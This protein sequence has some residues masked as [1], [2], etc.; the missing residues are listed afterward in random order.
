MKNNRMWLDKHIERLQKDIPTD[1]L[2]E[3]EVKTLLAAARN[4]KLPV[5][6]LEVFP[7]CEKKILYLNRKPEIVCYQIICSEALSHREVLGSLFSHQIAPHTFGD[8]AII[9]GTAYFVIMKELTQYF[10]QFFKEIGHKQ[11]QLKEVSIDILKNYT[12]PYQ[13]IRIIVPS[14]RLDNVLAKLCRTS[15]KVVQEKLNQDEVRINSEIVT[16]SS[17]ILNEQDTISIR[18]VGK[19]RFQK[20]IQETKKQNQVLLFWQYLS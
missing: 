1:F 15:R 9:D 7:G 10:E 12:Y 19:F 4:I 8:I 17:Y 18:R 20:V 3:N 6:A 14:M 2:E 13:E 11:V 5:Q 16:K